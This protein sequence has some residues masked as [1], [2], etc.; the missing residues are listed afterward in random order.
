MVTKGEYK[1][2]KNGAIRSEVEKHNF[3]SI[4]IFQ[5]RNAKWHQVKDEIKVVV[6]F[7]ISKILETVAGTVSSRNF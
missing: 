2:R 3:F 1:E 7:K 6:Y 4:P 5:G